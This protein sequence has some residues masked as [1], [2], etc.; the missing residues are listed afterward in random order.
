M[1]EGANESIAAFATYAFGLENDL[2]SATAQANELYKALGKETL[3]KLAED[4]KITSAE[5]LELSKTNE[6]LASV[7]DTTGMSASALGR[8]YELLQKEM[9]NTF[10]TTQD[11][12]DALG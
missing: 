3:T 4:G 12:V 9:I 6:D 11:F 8:Y 5:I 10:E 1:M 2:Y 7:L